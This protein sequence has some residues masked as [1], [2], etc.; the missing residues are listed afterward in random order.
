M[1]TIFRYIANGSGSGPYQG[2]RGKAN[3]PASFPQA[4][5]QRLHKTGQSVHT[6]VLLRILR[7]DV[8][9]VGLRI[10]AEYPLRIAALAVAEPFC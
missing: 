2:S 9:L 8:L 1:I 5:Y 7:V 10:L 4:Q 3:V 6:C